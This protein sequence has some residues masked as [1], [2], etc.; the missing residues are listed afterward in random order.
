[1]KIKDALFSVAVGYIVAT[2]PEWNM[3]LAMVFI[4]I[5]AAVVCWDVLIRIE[6]W[7]K[8]KYARGA[9]APGRATKNNFK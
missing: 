5:L 8:K 7:Q 9:A 3:K 4:G 2:T 1:M 6:D